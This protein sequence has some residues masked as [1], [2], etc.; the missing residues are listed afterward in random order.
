MT[1]LQ[2]LGIG[3]DGGNLDLRLR[4]YNGDI[5]YKLQHH[6]PAL[7]IYPPFATAHAEDH[8]DGGYEKIEQCHADYGDWYITMTALQGCSGK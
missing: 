2:D 3:H 5:R 8:Y 6:H 1:Q 7:K 4:V